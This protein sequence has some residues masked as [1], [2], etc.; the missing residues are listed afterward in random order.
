MSSNQTASTGMPVSDRYASFLVGFAGW[1]LDAFD[2]FLVVFCSS[3][4]FSRIAMAVA[5]P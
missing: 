1:T 4:G 2:F 3:S 5:S